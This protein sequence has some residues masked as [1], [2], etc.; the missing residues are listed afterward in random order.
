MLSAFQS[1]ITAQ[2][3]IS[4]IV[5]QWKFLKR[6]SGVCACRRS[7]FLV[8]WGFLGW[9]R[10]WSLEISHSQHVLICLGQM[11]PNALR[12][13][14]RRKIPPSVPPFKVTQGHLT[15]RRPRSRGRSPQQLMRCFRDFTL[16]SESSDISPMKRNMLNGM[17]G[18]TR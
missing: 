12:T 5:T 17:R 8:R 16:S 1:I 3:N 10:Y 2:L 14:I 9:G 15:R 11:V 6:C 4:Q 18:T 7:Q 13:E